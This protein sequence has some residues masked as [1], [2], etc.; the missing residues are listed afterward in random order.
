[1]PLD[2]AHVTGPSKI[3]VPTYLIFFAV[4]GLNYMTASANWL[5]PSP[6]LRYA[7]ELM[8]I[9]VWGA[10]FV[11]CAALMAWAM[12][13]ANR[14]EYRFALLVCALSMVIWTG[15]AVAGIWVEHVSFS[16]WTW[17][18]LVSAA[19]FATN[20]SLARN[21]QDQRRRV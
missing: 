16:A 8:P 11:T 10:L 21:D 7:N 12:V 18:G 15:I 9:R 6:M 17:P 1:M 19:C 14:T 5:L 13:R 3:M 20:L 4:N 2:P